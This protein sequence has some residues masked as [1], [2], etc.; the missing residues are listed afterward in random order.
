[1]TG[2]QVMA[3]RPGP[4]DV[5]RMSPGVYFLRVGAGDRE[6]EARLVLVR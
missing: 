1:M 2:R 5:S 6:A 3:L 4:N